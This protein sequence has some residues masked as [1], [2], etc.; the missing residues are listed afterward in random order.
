MAAAR[1]A[2]WRPQA[3]SRSGHGGEG[4]HRFVL[5]Q[6]DDGIHWKKGVIVSGDERL[7]DGYSHNC[8]LHRFDND[9]PNELMVQYSI[10]YDPPRTNEYVFFIKPDRHSGG[11]K[12]PAK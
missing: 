1:A 4:A 3:I 10:I 2:L 5:Y 11:G 9:E 8:I 6:S 12:R 7:P